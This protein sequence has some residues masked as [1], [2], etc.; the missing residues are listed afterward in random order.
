M[1]KFPT[2]EF[3]NVFIPFS[4]LFSTHL[5]LT[6]GIP[7]NSG[8]FWFGLQYHNGNTG[9]NN[10]TS[11]KSKYPMKIW[12]GLQKDNHNTYNHVFMS[13]LSVWNAANNSYTYINGPPTSCSTI[14]Y[15]WFDMA[16][17][18]TVASSWIPFTSVK[19]A[20]RQAS[21]SNCHSHCITRL[22]TRWRRQ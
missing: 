20:L 12:H 9:E 14:S 8:T 21:I 16:D 2:T 6:C 15:R 17:S 3:H 18:N 13:W 5:V 11:H 1:C 7:A 19:Y 4:K 22:A 10:G